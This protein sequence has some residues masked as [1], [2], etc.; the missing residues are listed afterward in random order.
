MNC[1]VINLLRASERRQRIAHKFNQHGISYSLIPGIDWQD[2]TDEAVVKH[3][4][5]D[6]FSQVRN[7]KRPQIHG[8]LACWLSHRKVWDLALKENENVVAIFED[9][10][11]PTN[12]T[13]A[14]LEAIEEFDEE[15]DI[16]FL[17]HGR[18]RKPLY[19]VLEI[20]EKFTCNLVKYDSIG[21]VGYV[22]TQ[23]AMKTLL[24]NYPL[25]V[26]HIDAL[27]HYYW[28]HGLKTY[29]LSPQVIFHGAPN[30]SQ[31][32]FNDESIND[33]EMLRLGL[34]SNSHQLTKKLNRFFYRLHSKYLPQIS[35]FRKRLKDESRISS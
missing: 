24:Y 17:Y 3:V 4:H 5:P 15:F 32:S 1:Y 26:I 33:E 35:A 25:M 34:V 20:N 11:M 8:T 12:E 29:M 31:H 2:L 18:S 6:Y 16:I 28:W 9:D 19:P 10:A 23:N 27:M 22:I 30:L 14:A 7:S 13:K 21:A